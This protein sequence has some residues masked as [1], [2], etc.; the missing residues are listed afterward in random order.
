MKKKI[1]KY[2]ILCET[3]KIGK[4]ERHPYKINFAETPIPN[5]PLDIMHID[6]FI[7]NPNIFLSAVDKLSR[8]GMLIPIKSRSIPDIRSGLTK[9]ISTFGIPKLIVSDNEPA[10]RSIEVRS[11]LEELG[12]EIYF[13]PTNKSEV[14]GIVERFHSTLSEIFCCTRK[15]HEELSQKELFRISV[16]L[17]NDT[18][19]SST[20]MRPKEIFYGV[21]EGERRSTE[22]AEII[23][24]RDKIYDEAIENLRKKQK[25]DLEFHNKNKQREPPLEIGEPV[26]VSRQGIKSKT[27][28]KYRRHEVARDNNKTFIDAH[29]RKIHKTKIRRQQK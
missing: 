25:I 12:I 23:E 10:L 19:H 11:M 15:N 4:Y 20:N 7:C 2:V 3:C 27:A 17:Y 24:K 5:K 14:N 21:K 9:L 1:R 16:G 26:Y 28:D 22:I 18:I 29:G 13:T 8:F 6:I